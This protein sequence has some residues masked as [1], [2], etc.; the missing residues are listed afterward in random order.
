[1]KKPPATNA[2]KALDAKRVPYEVLTF[3]ASDFTAEEACEKLGLPPEDVFK[4]LVARGDRTGPL[5]AVVPTPVRLSLKKLARISGNRTVALLAAPEMERLTGYVKGGC[6]PFGM[7]RAVPL[8]VDAS[9]AGRPR[10]V[11]SAGQRGVQL[12]LSG[13]DF[14]RASGAV[15]ADLAEE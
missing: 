3:A 8:Y 7:R 11:C 4:T 2:T 5:A 10:L 9:A 15:A 14:L 6:S 12:V 13:D 1:M